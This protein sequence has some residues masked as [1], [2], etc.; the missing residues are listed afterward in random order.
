MNAKSMLVLVLSCAFL[1]AAP[2]LAGAEE[3]VHVARSVTTVSG[4]S[5]AAETIRNLKAVEFGSGAAT[6]TVEVDGGPTALPIDY[7]ALFE[8]GKTE[9]GGSSVADLAI[10][11]VVGSMFL[12]AVQV[13]SRLGRRF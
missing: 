2:Q 13:L 6:V 5:L 4:A 9:L 7:A 12:R 8:S 11:A 1:I 3:P 10:W